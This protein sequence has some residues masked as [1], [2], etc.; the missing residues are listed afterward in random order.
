MVGASHAW[1]MDQQREQGE[2]YMR[3]AGFAQVLQVCPK[4][5][6][7]NFKA[8]SISLR[9]HGTAPSLMSFA[10]L[11]VCF[12]SESREKH[13]NSIEWNETANMWISRELIHIT[14]RRVA[15]HKRKQLTNNVE[16]LLL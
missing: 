14:S 5:N 4:Q 12:R 6:L 10:G 13:K 11:Q 2:Q 3:F 1:R 9:S 7:Q 15:M 16:P 8:P